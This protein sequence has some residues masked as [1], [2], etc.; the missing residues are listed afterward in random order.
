MT[1][2]R[3]HGKPIRESTLSN[4]TRKENSTVAVQT[5]MPFHASVASDKGAVEG[6][7]RALAA[8]LAPRI[9]ANAIAPSL[10]DTPLAKQL[11]ST[12][13]KRKASEERH[14]LKRLGA[15]DDIAGIAVFLPG[16][17]AAW[18]TGQV[19]HVDGGVSSVRLFS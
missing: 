11:L 1:N 18:I 3:C 19:L 4:G 12:E 17:D 6:L 8:E 7:T 9:R 14:P 16:E 15:T 13:T 10:T 5:G 2:G